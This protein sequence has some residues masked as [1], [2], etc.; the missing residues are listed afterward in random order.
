M[1]ILKYYRIKNKH[2]WIFLIA[3]ATSWFVYR[4]FIVANVS[5]QIEFLITFSMGFLSYLLIKTLFEQK[6]VIH[7]FERLK[8]LFF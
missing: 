6:L 7:Y 5:Y 1:N 4:K 2:I 3:L 8:K